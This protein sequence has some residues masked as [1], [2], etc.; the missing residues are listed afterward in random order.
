M[1]NKTST[2]TGNKCPSATTTVPWKPLHV[3]GKE[4]KVLREAGSPG[5]SSAHSMGCPGVG[6]L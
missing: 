3:H 2:I 5:I 6:C 4:Q 1:L